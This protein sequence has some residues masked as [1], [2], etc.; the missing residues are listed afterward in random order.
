MEICLRLKHNINILI[1]IISIK[2]RFEF[3]G[4]VSGQI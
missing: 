3:T 2:N 4:K 1:L